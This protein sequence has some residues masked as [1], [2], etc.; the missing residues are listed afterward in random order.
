M[1]DITR[2]QYFL[3]GLL[4][5]LLGVQFLVTENFVLN[6]DVTTF[7]AEKTKDPPAALNTAA[8]KIALESELVP[9]KTIRPP[10]FVGYLLTSLGAVLILHSW[11][12][13]RPD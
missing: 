2:N 5:L 9:P 11:G 13:K 6:S 8:T 3:M 12:M 1:M 4:L 7:L 10:D